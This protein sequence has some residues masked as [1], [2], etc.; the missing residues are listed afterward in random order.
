MSKSDILSAHYGLPTTSEGQSHNNV[1]LNGAGL[2]KLTAKSHCRWPMVFQMPLKEKSH[3]YFCRLK[4]MKCL[5]PDRPSPGSQVGKLAGGDTEHV[6][7]AQ[8][9]P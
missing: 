7:E 3:S 5:C 6:L 8:E 1:L 2:T 4:E 9:S